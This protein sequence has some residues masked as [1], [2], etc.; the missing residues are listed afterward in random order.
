MKGKPSGRTRSKK[1][2]KMRGGSHANTYIFYHIYCNQSTVN[3]VGD[4]A[5]KIIFSGLYKDVNKIYCFLTGKK[6]N[7]N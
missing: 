3:I 5:T 7:I 6:E 4:Q 2:R 1:T